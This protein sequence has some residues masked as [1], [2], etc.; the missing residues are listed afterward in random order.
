MVCG[1]LH[2]Q[3]VQLNAWTF[4]TTALRA[5]RHVIV[6]SLTF[7]APRYTMFA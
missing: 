6:T 3:R 4:A 7:N 5:L 1:I 2:S